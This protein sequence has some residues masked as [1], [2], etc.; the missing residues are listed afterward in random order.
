VFN[1]MSSRASFV[2]PSNVDFAAAGGLAV[3]E[4]QASVRPGN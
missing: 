4:Q 2:W 1:G 3:P